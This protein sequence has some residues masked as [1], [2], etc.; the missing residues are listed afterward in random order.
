VWRATVCSKA[1][2]S[3]PLGGAS[4][5][6]GHSLCAA[7]FDLITA[8][9][10]RRTIRPARGARH[11]DVAGACRRAPPKRAPP[12]LRSALARVGDTMLHCH[13]FAPKLHPTIL[14]TWCLQNARAFALVRPPVQADSVSLSV[15]AP[16]GF[17]DFLIESV[18]FPRSHAYKVLC[19]GGR[20]GKESVVL[21]ACRLPFSLYN[22]HMLLPT[23]M[24]KVIHRVIT[25]HIQQETARRGLRHLKFSVHCTARTRVECWDRF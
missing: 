8:R 24:L 4:A 2:A 19:G 16:W 7:A 11:A 22:G 23:Y 18:F 20:P 6:G 12:M 21:G 17:S 15:I 10:A 9:Q 14:L 13:C 5:R 25:E 1:W 3:W